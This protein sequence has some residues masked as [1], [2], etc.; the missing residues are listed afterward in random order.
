MSLWWS[1]KAWF[2]SLSDCRPLFG[3]R[4][5]SWIILG[6]SMAIGCMLLQITFGQPYKDAP[7][8]KWLIVMFFFNMSYVL[9][10]VAMDSAMTDLA[11]REPLEERGHLQSTYYLLR[12]S[13]LGVTAVIVSFG[14]SSAEYGG[15]FDWGFTLPQVTWMGVG[16]G[17]VGLPFF[18]L[19]EETKV[20]ETKSM[21][22]QFRALFARLQLDAVWRVGLFCLLTNFFTQISNNTSYDIASQWCGV[23]PWV[24][25]LFSSVLAQFFNVIAIY[26]ART[27]LINV[28]W[29]RTLT[30]SV[31]GLAVLGFIPSVLIDLGYVRNQFFFAG[32]PLL[33]EVSRAIFNIVS[34]YCA[35]EVAEPGSEGIIY[36]FMTTAMNVAGPLSSLLSSNLAGAFHLY[37]AKGNLGTDARTGFKMLVRVSVL[38]C[39][40]WMHALSQS[41][42]R[43]G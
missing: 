11:Q 32:A 8:W 40:V 17:L 35:V 10:D 43:I 3:Y 37:D 26:I 33:N 39:T 6:F 30:W 19:L 27:F 7:A 12:H 38:A 24:N 25:G 14:F 13:M 15:T 1:F 4:R 28:S 41:Y 23:K 22:A 34:M 5:K 29:H 36:G 18:Y 31:V 42:I 9:G 20:T 2:G 16:L 21:L